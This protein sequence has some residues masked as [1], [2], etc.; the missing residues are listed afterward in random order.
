MK[1]FANRIGYSDIE[2]FE[3]IEQKTDV[4]WLSEKWNARKPVS[5]S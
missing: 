3:V 4:S 1:K 5:Q 2:P